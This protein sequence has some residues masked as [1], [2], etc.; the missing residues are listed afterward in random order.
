MTTKQ[1]SHPHQPELR[2]TRYRQSRYWAIW[3]AE[4]LVAVTLYKKGARAISQLINPMKTKENQKGLLVHAVNSDGTKVRI[5]VNPRSKKTTLV[6]YGLKGEFA[7][8]TQYDEPL[9]ALLAS[10]AFTLTSQKAQKQVNSLFAPK[11]KKTRA[12]RIKAKE[13]T[14]ID[15]LDPQTRDRVNAMLEALE[16]VRETDEAF[17]ANRDAESVLTHHQMVLMPGESRPKRIPEDIELCPG[18]Q[19]LRRYKGNLITVTM[20]APREYFYD[21]MVY[22]T[23]THISWLVSGYQIS[24]NAFFGLP[25]KHR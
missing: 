6:S 11:A 7:A 3:N 10:G 9:P 12:S 1:S 16:Y 5:M 23:L 2:I 25:I 18:T 14:E 22:P 17:E 13:Q 15:T 19:I 24:G 21:G 20:L 8:D 4:N